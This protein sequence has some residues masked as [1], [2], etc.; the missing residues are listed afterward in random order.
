MKKNNSNSHNKPSIIVQ[1]FINEITKKYSPNF[2]I[3]NKEH[4]KGLYA[5]VSFFAKI[6]N[7]NIDTA[8][9][10]Q[11]LNEC[12]VPDN[13]LN[14]ADANVLSVIAHETFHEYDRKRLTTPVVFILYAFPQIFAIFSLLSFL[15][16]WWGIE[17]LTCISFL[18][19]LLPLPAPGRMWIEVRAYR[20]NMMF[21]K[22]VH[23]T[24]P[25]GLI[26]MAE[27][28]SKQFTGPSYYF[29]W[30]FKK[31]IVKLLLK[32]VQHDIYEEYKQWLLKEG[33]IANSEILANVQN[34]S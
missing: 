14:R 26:G 12:W 21:L 4:K 27:H 18:F 23:Q 16:I 29:M 13:F 2:V 3:K 30:P 34:N 33:F 31:H 6:F 32:E 28:Y 19:F 11:I 24:A 17:W 25:E 22:Y 15:S 7:P 20:V 5:I 10:T 8:Y 9:V 1:K